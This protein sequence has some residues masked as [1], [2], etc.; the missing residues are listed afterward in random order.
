[1][2]VY[3]TVLYNNIV[4]KRVSGMQ[5]YWLVTITVLVESVCKSLVGLIISLQYIKINHSVM[6]WKN[7]VPTNQ[8]VKFQ[9]NWKCSGNIESNLD[10][11]RMVNWKVND[12][13]TLEINVWDHINTH[14]SFKFTY[15]KFLCTVTSQT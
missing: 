2:L 13:F 9:N 15:R 1:M 11:Y 10:S 12:P 14:I 6:H 5:I 3:L 4:D 7:I 8:T